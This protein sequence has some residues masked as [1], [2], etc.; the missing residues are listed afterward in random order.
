MSKAI[1]IDIF[2]TTLR[3]GQQCPGA[4]MPFEKNIEYAHL[5]RQFGVDIL[6]AG[7]PSSSEHEFNTVE[8][9]AK[10]FSDYEHAPVVTALCQ[11]RSEQF[12]KTIQA[13]KPAAKKGKA[14]LHTY[15]PV[16]PEL[17]KHSLG[18]KKSKE[19]AKIISQVHKYITEVAAE[20]IQVQFSPEGYS[21]MGLNF[22]FTTDLI[23]AAVDAGATIINCP[24]TIGGACRVQGDDYFVEHM[25]RHA[26]IVR[27][28]YPEK[29]IVWSAHCHN[30]LG[31]ALDNTINAVLY[32]PATQIEGCINGIG[33][34]AGNVSLEQCVMYFHQFQKYFDQSRCFKTGINIEK[35]QEIS[36]FVHKYMLPRQPHSPISGCN[37]ARHTSGGHTN[38]IIKNPTVYQPYNPEET[39]NKITLLFGPSSG[40]NHAKSII[41]QHGEYC[42]DHEKAAIAQFIK[43]WYEDRYK[44]IT[45][46]ELMNAFFA[47]RKQESLVTPKTNIQ[48]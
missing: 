37:A 17:M 11:M 24:D 22:A 35:T 31:L 27:K 14:R 19:K 25:N 38:A 30:D 43:S 41:E 48:G 13:L 26:A 5:A 16:D 33:E 8:T 45:D 28:A 1:K 47:Y 36:N 34:R 15:I 20:G 29:Q 46:E 21:R 6:E 7:F 18:E 12:E 40:G 42:G 39:G 23:L 10:E 44:G 3:D 32:G 9:I 2:D 4:G